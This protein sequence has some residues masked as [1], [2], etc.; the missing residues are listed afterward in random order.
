[1]IRWGWW[2]WMLGCGPG[3]VPAAPDVVR[4]QAVVDERCVSACLDAEAMRAVSAEVIERGCRERC[5]PAPL[6]TTG[7]E[8]ALRA[9]QR[10]TLR[11]TLSEQALSDGRRTWGIVLADGLAVTLG[12]GPAPAEWS[13]KMG[14]VGEATGTWWDGAPP[15]PAPDLQGYAPGPHLTEITPPKGP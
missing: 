15:G 14:Q 4:A 6:A 5:G 11:G 3:P 2:A 8:L 12:Y 7:A 9:G 13:A 10:W 1:V